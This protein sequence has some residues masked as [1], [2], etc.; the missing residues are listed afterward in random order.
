VAS[1]H[2]DFRCIQPHLTLSSLGPCRTCP[3]VGGGSE[4][5]VVFEEMNLGY[6]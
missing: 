2:V 3:R 1:D 6:G 4:V 5:D